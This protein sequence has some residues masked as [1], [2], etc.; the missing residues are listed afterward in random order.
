MKFTYAYIGIL[1]MM[2]ALG[3][4][5]TGPKPIQYGTDSC[6]F[7]RMTIVDRQH[8]SEIVTS[9]GKVYKFD[10]IECMVNFREELEETS[11]AHFLC[12]D[13]NTPGELMDATSATFLISEAI[14]SPMGANLTAFRNAEDAAAARQ[15]YGGQL[16]NWNQLGAFLKNE[17]NAYAR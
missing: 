3:A 10:A 2:A 8:A 11:I 7:C 4:C 12:N 13:F 5:N 9:K 6:H 17:N 14:P 15:Q 1:V 16:Y